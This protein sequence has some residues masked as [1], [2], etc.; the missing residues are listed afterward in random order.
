M[1]R[2][3]AFGGRDLDLNP[4]PAILVRYVTSVHAVNSPDLSLPRRKNEECSIMIW[5]IPVLC[6]WY[7]TIFPCTPSSLSNT[8]VLAALEMVQRKTYALGL[9]PARVD[10]QDQSPRPTPAS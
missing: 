5:Q 6:K 8:L 7:G 10:H 2:A 1:D 3:Q 9:Q 4:G